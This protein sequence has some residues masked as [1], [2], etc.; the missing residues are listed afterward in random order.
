MGMDNS[1][2]TESGQNHCGYGKFMVWTI[3]SFDIIKS[4][5]ALV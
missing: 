4:W 1:Y 3:R 5:S 2:H